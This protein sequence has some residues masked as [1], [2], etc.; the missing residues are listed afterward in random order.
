MDVGILG[1]MP[2]CSGKLEEVCDWPRLFSNSGFGIKLSVMSCRFNVSNDWVTLRMGVGPR[3]PWMPTE[4]KRESKPK[5]KKDN[6][7]GDCIV[8]SVILACKGAKGD[9]VCY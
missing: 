6:L 1:V 9:E 8:E 4:A 3:N 2:T 5:Y 7:N